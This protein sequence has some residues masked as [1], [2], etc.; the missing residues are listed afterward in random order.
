MFSEMISSVK[1]NNNETTIILNK[2]WKVAGVDFNLETKT[3]N[4]RKKWI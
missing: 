2:L 1:T 4:K 3:K